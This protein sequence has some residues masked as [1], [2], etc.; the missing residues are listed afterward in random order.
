LEFPPERLLRPRGDIIRDMHMREDEVYERVR[1]YLIREFEIQ[2][3]RIAP[4]ADLFDDLEL[5]SIDALDWFAK[6]ESEIDLPI[7]EN[8]LKKIRTVQDVVDYVLRN[9]R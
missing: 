6:M 8:E 2:E 7:V 9:L 1:Q 3:E 5:D 4:E